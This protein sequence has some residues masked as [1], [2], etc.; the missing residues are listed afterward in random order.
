MRFLFIGG[1][2]LISSEVTKLALAR[3]HEVFLLNRSSGADYAALGAEHIRAD[4]REPQQVKA[5]IAGMHFDAVADFICFTEEQ[6]AVSFELFNGKTDQFVFISSASAYQKPARGFTITESTPLINPFWKYSRDKIAC[7]DYFIKRYREDGFPITIVRPSHTYG[8]DKLPVPLSDAS[9]NWTY[10]E[11]IRR[12]EPTIVPGDGTS[13]WTITHNTDFAVGFCGLLGRA[14]AIG[15]PFHITS[16]EYLRWDTIIEIIGKTLGVTPN[17]AHIS[18][19][20]IIKRFPE[21]EGPLLGDK[22]ECAVFDNSKIKRLVPEYRAVTPFETG[23]RAAVDYMN[24]NPKL[25]TVDENYIN[26]MRELAK[27]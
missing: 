7:E 20:R 10:L 21:Y 15:H 12:G 19:D 8:F 6:A 4:I 14:A 5:A 9:G 26:K 23:A 25:Q 3:G 22:A 11:M 2:G 16:D 24:N 1:T 17:I 18:S 27:L 13:L